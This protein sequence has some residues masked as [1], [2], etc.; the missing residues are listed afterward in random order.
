MHDSGLPFFISY[1][2]Y[3]LLFN[4]SLTLKF[5][6]WVFR[7]SFEYFDSRKLLDNFRSRL[8]SQV[9]SKAFSHQQLDGLK[10]R[11][12]NIWWRIL[13]H[14]LGKSFLEIFIWLLLIY[15]A[16]S[17]EYFHSLTRGFD[18][19][20]SRSCSFNLEFIRNGCFAKVFSISTI[21]S[22]FFRNFYLARLK[23]SAGRFYYQYF[24]Y[25]QE[26]QIEVWRI[27]VL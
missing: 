21:W 16:K 19:I 8:I 3:S 24:E 2:L 12:Y 22:F 11:Y 6:S 14:N 10:T 23:P 20:H 13:V 7:K 5:T 1:S 18:L 25:F 17:V 15:S 9:E 4:L 26:Q 27:F